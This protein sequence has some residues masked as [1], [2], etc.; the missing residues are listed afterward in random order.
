M[1]S[2]ASH[3]P[4]CSRPLGQTFL[5][6]DHQGALAQCR[7]CGHQVRTRTHVCPNCG[8]QDPA[9]WPRAAR[10]ALA[11]AAGV[12]AVGV[13]A[14]VVT[15]NGLPG[16]AAPSLAA[17]ATRPSTMARPETARVERVRPG[18]KTGRVAAPHATP[19][20]PKAP[21][22]HASPAVADSAP[23]I[24]TDPVASR[25][26]A[27][28]T[29]VTAA[30]AAATAATVPETRWTTTW[31]NVRTG[32]SNEAPVLRVL[33][34]GTAVQV[35]VGKWGWWAVRVGSDSV[36]YVAGELLSDRK[37]GD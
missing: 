21:V 5:P 19:A 37:P 17:A 3:C 15:T 14:M 36:G 13:L 25:A 4:A 23:R 26:P 9:R 11:A 35:T 34:P 6:L 31:V 32:P 22:H 28:T 18:S 20:A 7:S 29:L 10:S 12:A 27:P 24:A 33:G 8:A 30:G 1:L 2:V 16:H